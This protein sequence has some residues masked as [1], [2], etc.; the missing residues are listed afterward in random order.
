MPLALLLGKVWL[1]AFYL[2]DV[3]IPKDQLL[4]SP[5]KTQ[6]VKLCISEM[7]WAC[8]GQ[9]QESKCWREPSTPVPSLLTAGISLVSHPVMEWKDF[10]KCHVALWLSS[11]PPLALVY[12]RRLLRDPAPR[13]F[14]FFWKSWVLLKTLRETDIFLKINVAF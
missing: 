7:D 14:D 10:G 9:E 6:A 4:D 5:K 8:S 1:L 13:D 12:L 11:S 2:E 3:F